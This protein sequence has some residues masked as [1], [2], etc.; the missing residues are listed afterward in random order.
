MEYAWLKLNR[1]SSDRSLVDQMSKITV[2]ATCLSGIRRLGT[3]L[4][5]CCDGNHDDIKSYCTAKRQFHSNKHMYG[6]EKRSELDR[7]KRGWLM[8]ICVVA[9]T[10]SLVYS[11]Q[12]HCQ[13]APNER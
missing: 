9:V 2:T 4:G 13:Y 10:T 5:D 6:M 1:A 3:G 7:F 12:L 11:R 8:C